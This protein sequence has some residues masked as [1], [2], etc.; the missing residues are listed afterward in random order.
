MTITGTLTAGPTGR[1][2]IPLAGHGAGEYR[3][4]A[5]TGAAQAGGVLALVFRNGDAPR[6]EPGRHRFY[7]GLLGR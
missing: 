4:L 5:V 6:P 1:L 7:G 3:R 2:Q